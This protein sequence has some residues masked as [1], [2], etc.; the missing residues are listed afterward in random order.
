[1][2]ELYKDLDIAS[3]IKKKRLE[4]VGH[5]ARREQGRT[6]KK[7][8]ESKPERSERKEKPKLKWLTNVKKDLREMMFR[9]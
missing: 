3:D 9:R 8:F 1:M 2:R 7:A 6:D 4:R 5:V